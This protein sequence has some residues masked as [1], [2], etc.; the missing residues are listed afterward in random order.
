MRALSAHSRSYFNHLCLRG[1]GLG[2]ATSLDFFITA[3]ALA[4]AAALFIGV[5]AFFFGTIWGRTNV[6]GFGRG[7][8]L[9][10]PVKKGFD[11]IFSNPGT[12]RV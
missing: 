9:F 4:N 3:T 2:G 1:I 11:K 6:R 12:K 5:L 7:N 10:S 8:T